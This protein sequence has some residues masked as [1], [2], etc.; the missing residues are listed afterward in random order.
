MNRKRKY[1]NVYQVYMSLHP[2][3]PFKDVKKDDPILCKAFEIYYS[4]L[5]KHN[6]R[7]KLDSTV[8]GVVA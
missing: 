7:I 8:P 6:K 2:E 1:G 5:D 3:I 4:E